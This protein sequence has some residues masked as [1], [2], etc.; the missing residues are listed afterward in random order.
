MPPVPQVNYGAGYLHLVPT[1]TP[2]LEPIQFGILQDVQLDYTSAKAYLFG[3]K[4]FALA[5]GDKEAKL[6]GKCKTAQI[7]GA[8]LAAAIAGATIA[9]GM[10]EEVPDESGTIAAAAVTV[11]GSAT[12]LQDLGVKDN[13]TGL[14]FVK[15][16]SAPAVGQYSQTGGVYTFNA[17]DNGKVVLISYS[18][19][20]A[21]TG[22]TITIANPAMALSTT[23]A[24]NLYNS[25]QGN[26]SK[27]LGCVLNAI[28]IPKLSIPF[29]SQEF[30]MKDV[31][32]EALADTS[33]NVGKLYT[34]E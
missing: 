6:T 32:F 30:T 26:A 16:S 24:L 33:G 17:T 9:N 7:K 28:V 10:A 15:V 11:V 27:T 14:P 31:D 4:Q 20:T 25:K 12:F 23:F 2:V 19:T 3:D 34:L 18:K 21:G 8:V 22:K 1:G 13:I 29:K 5:A